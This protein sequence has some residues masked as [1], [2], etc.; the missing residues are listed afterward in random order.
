[1]IRWTQYVIRKRQTGNLQQGDIVFRI[2]NKFSYMFDR[3]FLY[4]IGNIHSHRIRMFF[5]KYVYSMDIASEVT[6]Y[7]NIEIRNPSGIKI[8]KGTIIGENAILDGRAGLEIGNNV[9][10]SSNVRIWTLQHDYRDPD[11]ACNPEH[12]GPVKICDRAWIGPHTIILHDITV[13]EG[14]VVAGGAVVTKDVPPY[15]LVGGG[16]G[17]TDRKAPKRASLRVSRWSSKVPVNRRNHESRLRRWKDE[18]IYYIRI[19]RKCDV[20]LGLFFVFFYFPLNKITFFKRKVNLKKHQVVLR[21]LDTICID[22]CRE[23]ENEPIYAKKVNEEGSEYEGS[24]W[25]WWNDAQNVPPI[26]QRCIGQIEKY[27]AG[28]TVRLVTEENHERY[29]SLPEHIRDKYG[30]GIITYT[31]F[32]DIVRMT[33]MSKYGGIYMDATLL[34]TGEIPMGYLDSDFYTVKARIEKPWMVV[35]EGKL[36]SFFFACKKGNLLIETTRKMMLR[37]WERYNLLVDYLWIDYLWIACANKLSQVKSMLDDVPYTNPSIYSLED[38]G[39]PCS[40]S[41]YMAMVHR[42]DTV[43]YKF[44]YKG[45]S[46]YSEITDNGELTLKGRIINTEV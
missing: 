38:L 13:G 21:F 15:T 31:H 39:L 43:L 10:F 45:S 9:N 28:R 26:V 23:V 33:L 42:D 1:M 6:M 32:S 20:K 35:S 7:Y 29:F 44:S 25:V 22:L 17:K 34:Q 2:A 40:A 4:W 12:Y 36:S 11:F 3:L 18:L 24:I 37:Y 30:K 5:Y 19:T 46:K 14:A 8:G 41:E 27:A 16:T